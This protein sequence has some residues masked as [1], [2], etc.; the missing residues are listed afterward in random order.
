MPEPSEY[1]YYIKEIVYRFNGRWKY[2]SINMRHRLPSKNI[3]LTPPP[4][5]LSVLKIFLDIYFDDFST[6]RNVYHL[7]GG[8]YLQ[9]GNMPL[10]F[11]KQLK[12][13][14]LIG[15]VPFGADFND[16]I[17]PI[18]EDIKCLESGLVIKTLIGNAW[19]IGGVGCVTA[20]LLQG[21][22][23]ANVKWHGANHGCSTCN[24]MEKRFAKIESQYSK[25]ERECLAVEYELAKPGPLRILKWDRHIQTPQDVY[26][27]MARKAHTLLDAT[28]NAF[29]LNGEK[30]SVSK[31]CTC[32]AVEAKVLKLAF[33]LSITENSYQKL[34]KLLENEYEML[35]EAVQH[36]TGIMASYFGWVDPQ[37]NTRSNAMNKL[38]IDPNLYTI[39]SGYTTLI[40]KKLEFYNSIIYIV[41]ESDQDLVQMKLRVGDFV[42]LLEETEGIAYAKIESIFCYQANNGQFHAFFY[43]NGFRQQ[44]T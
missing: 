44:Q 15:F 19:V 8:V 1:E 22:G 33:S 34:Q 35:L 31:L 43:L 14:F 36:N 39:L 28:F 5:H 23:L 29:N 20:D 9:F 16:F 25:A 40:N 18:L 27:S 3:T 11:R 13:Y 7:L 4:K 37:F 2:R 6:Y 26:H 38:A 12:N 32:W 41:L 42:E 30:I 10:N 24:Q 17:I 21:N